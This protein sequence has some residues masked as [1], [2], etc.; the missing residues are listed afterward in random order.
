MS[1]FAVCLQR[2][3]ILYKIIR[4]LLVTLLVLIIVTPMALYVAISLPSVQEKICA[5]AERELSKLL[6]TVVSIDAIEITPFNRVA[7]KD[8]TIKDAYSAEAFEIESI[9]AGVDIYEFF[10]HDKII[11]THAELI[12]LDAKLY[13]KD[14]SSPLNIYNIINALKPKDKTKPPTIFDLRVNTVVIRDAQVSYDIQSAVALNNQFDKNH[15][16]VTNFNADIQLPQL[17]NDDFII[18]IK[19]FNASEK[20]GINLKNLKGYFHVASTGI[21]VNGLEIALDNSKLLFADWILDFN[22]WEGLSKR[23]KTIPLDIALKKGSHITLSDLGPFI[24]GFKNMSERFDLDINLN[25]EINDLSINRLNISHATKPLT[26]KAQGSLVG[27]KTPK[28]AQIILSELSLNANANDVNSILEAANIANNDIRAKIA[29]VGNLSING[30]FNGQPLDA[31]FD[32]D[33]NTALGNADIYLDYSIIAEAKRIDLKGDVKTSGLEI[34]KITN[35]DKFGSTAGEIAFDIHLNGDNKNGFIDGNISHFDFNKYR[36]NNIKTKILV[37]NNF[38]EGLADI[39]DPNINFSIEGEAN[40]DKKDPYLNV[41]ANAKTI[42]FDKINLTDKYHHLSA[43]IDANIKGLDFDK[44]TGYVNINNLHYSNNPNKELSIDQIS[45]E[46]RNDST[47]QALTISSNFLNAS[48]NGTYS[49]KSLVP[50]VKDILSHSLP[51]FFG[52]HAHDNATTLTQSGNQN[53]FTFDISLEKDENVFNFFN[54]NTEL[55]VPITLKGEVNHPQH[56]MNMVGNVPYL[57]V[58]NKLFEKTYLEVDIDQS[59]DRCFVKMFT[60]FPHKHESVPVEVLCDASNNQLDAHISWV[61]NRKTAYR[62]DISL[63]TLFSRDENNKLI[64]DLNINPSQLVFN[65]SV[66]TIQQASVHYADKNIEVKNFD[67]RNDEQFITMSGKASASP[68]DELRLDLKNVNLDYIFQTL[69]ISNVVIGGDAT[70]TFY[71]SQVFSKTPIAYTPKLSVKDISYNACV[72]GDAAIKA[73]WNNDM[74]A[75][76]LDADITQDDGNHS[77]IYG[78]IFPIKESL[79]IRFDANKINIGFLQ[80]F[81]NAFASDVQGH[82]SGNAR[83]FGTFKLIDLTGDLLANDLKL[84]INFTNTYYT[85]SDS[86]IIRPGILNFKNITLHDQSGN[87]ALLNG[88][89]E[90]EYFKKASFNFDITNAKNFLCY[91][92]KEKIGEKWYG[93]INGN[94]FAHIDGKPGEVN[95]GVEMETAPNSSFTFILSDM[96]NAY[97]YKFL[98][99]RDKNA[100]KEVGIEVPVVDNEPPAV[101]KFR[102]Q[103]KKKEEDAPSVYNM[104]INVTVTPD[105]QMILVMDPIGGDKIKGRGSGQLQMGYKSSSEEL[106]MYGTYEI[107]EGSYNFT[108]QDIILKDFKIRDNSSITFNGDPF[109]AMLNITAAYNVKANISDLDESFLDDKELNRTNVPVN[110]LLYIKD[111]MTQPNISFGLEFPTLKPDAYSKV[112]SIISTDEMMKRQI[113]YLLALNRFYTPEYMSTTKG[114]EIFSVASSTLSSQLSSMLGQLSDNWSIAPYLRSDLGDFSDV[115]VDVALSSTL[116][117][118]RLRLNGNFGYRDKSLNTNQFIGDFD[119]EYLLNNSG[120]WRL[121]AYNRYNDQNYYLKTATTTQGIGIMYRKEFNNFFNFLKWKKKD[122]TKEEISTDSTSTILTTPIDSIII[123]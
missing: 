97:D 42:N 7:L 71:A 94:G 62:G 49:Y 4:T 96:Q 48:I 66:W 9:G 103:Q 87:T 38:I 39:D 121:K 12:G 104:N 115:E 101:K 99:F 1:I 123:K 92:I 100:L 35:N 112:M 47:Q 36:F 84:K 107:D 117:N 78:E 113:L 20:S 8:V 27:I 21:K 63:S 51:V 23:I 61:L 18:D 5:V 93:H 106:K 69:N 119:I 3:K 64:T 88:K 46:S 32:G 114:N 30:K 24:P 109:S 65:D 80:T 34:A 26:L 58:G 68:E 41:Y 33:I 85:A 40:I 116:L 102:K 79:D 57:V 14:S 28:T 108:L 6:G 52:E 25:G 11:I 120:T 111:E 53:N 95:I 90:H 72:L 37:D 74:Q 70:G 76:S 82:A 43:E 50:A 110:A 31:I 75:V 81:M 19:R 73:H 55:F 56:R 118:N 54:I 15:I 86:V 44:A 17:K 91:D 67:V 45:I 22:N 2:M 10:K 13:K 60:E 77:R 105:A 122:K 98:T 29:Q 89:V 83:L 59:I 16:K